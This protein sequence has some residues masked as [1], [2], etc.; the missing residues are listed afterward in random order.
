MSFWSWVSASEK[1]ASCPAALVIASTAAS[2]ASVVSELAT[3]VADIGGSL[4]FVSGGRGV[5]NSFS[6][7]PARHLRVNVNGC[8]TLCLICFYSRAIVRSMASSIANPQTASDRVR[9][10]RQREQEIVAATRLLFD[11]RGLQDAPMEDI[12]RA[13]GIN[14]GLIYRYFSS[15]E[16]L[17]VLTLTSYLAELAERL[18]D[19]TRGAGPGRASRG[20][21]AALHRLL[22]RA[23]GIS[24]LRHVADA[25]ARRGAA[26]NGLRRRLDSPR[27]RHGRL[28]GQALEDPRP[29]CAA[30]TSSPSTI[31][32]SPQTTSTPRRSARCT[33]RVSEWAY[34]SVPLD[35]SHSRF[36]PSKCRR[37]ASLTCC[38]R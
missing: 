2:A 18:E 24:G 9:V 17:F 21:L 11:E 10:R 29:R 22:P 14:R 35:P 26:R 4:L 1:V 34:A 30:G 15:K 5:G 36:R 31:P 8:Q 27:A 19:D 32:T 23:P 7:C 37:P 25:Q 3:G 28:L 33:W 38:P 20:R 12:A 13:V 6:A 16:E